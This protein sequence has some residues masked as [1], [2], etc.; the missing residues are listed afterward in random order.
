MRLP[1]RKPQMTFY[2]VFVKIPDKRNILK[3]EPDIGV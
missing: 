3:K 1:L 2:S